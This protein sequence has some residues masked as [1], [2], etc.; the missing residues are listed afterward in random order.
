MLDGQKHKEARIEG[1][2]AFPQNGERCLWVKTVEHQ[3]ILEREYQIQEAVD[4][5]D[6]WD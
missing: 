3:P 6:G 1:Q 5:T 2:E 4:E